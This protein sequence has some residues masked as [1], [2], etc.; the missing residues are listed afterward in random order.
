MTSAGTRSLKGLRRGNKEAVLFLLM[1]GGEM[2]RVRIASSTGLTTASVTQLVKD[3]IAEGLVAESGEVPREVAG[4][5]ETLLKFEAG[6][7]AAIGVNIESDRTHISACTWDEVLREEIYPTAELL[8]DGTDKLNERIR[9]LAVL[10]RGKK[11]VGT[12]IAIVG[13]TDDEKGISL[14]SYGLLPD[15]YNLAKDIAAGTGTDVEVTNNVRAQARA[16]MTG[17]ED[18]FMLV[19]HGPGVGCA[20]ISDCAIVAGAAN[21]AGEIGHTVVKEDGELCRCGKRGCLEAYVSERHIKALYSNKTGNEIPVSE[22][23]DKYGEDET[24]TEILDGC[25]S[26]LAVSIG[27]AAMLLNPVRVLATGGI[28]S[29]EKLF[30][31]FRAA[32]EKAGFGGSFALS[33]IGDDKKLKAFSGARHIMLC[34]VFGI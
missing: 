6:S 26:L 20:V 22:I 33:R 1:R 25:L 12:G 5:R 15:G 23:Y 8:K 30:D 10:C 2:S 17:K 31:A 11:F 7:V 16:L 13:L 34:R 29:R 19:K 28:F 27:N 4:R 24:A 9:A 14:K 3:L 21:R 32:V 18:S